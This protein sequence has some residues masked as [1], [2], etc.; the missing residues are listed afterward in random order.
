MIRNLL[1]A[2]FLSLAVAQTGLAE[3]MTVDV[4]TAGAEQLAEALT[5]VG[6]AKAEAIIEYRQANGDFEHIDELVNVKGIGLRTVDRNR[7]RIELD[8]EPASEG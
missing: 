7:D 3:E 1:I 4:N 6:P 5:G 2:L 8:G